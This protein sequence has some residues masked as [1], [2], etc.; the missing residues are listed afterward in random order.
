[1]SEAIIAKFPVPNRE[2]EA[3]LRESPEKARIATDVRAKIR[4]KFNGKLISCSTDY[5][6]DPETGEDG[7]TFLV[8]LDTSHR[9]AIELGLAF[10]LPAG[11]DEWMSVI[12][13]GNQ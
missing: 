11:A 5:L 1:M 10:E 6:P 4:S 7:L 3:F 9:E 8:A 13:Y 2:T 12:T